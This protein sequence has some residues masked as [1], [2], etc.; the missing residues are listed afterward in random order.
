MTAG[1]RMREATADDLDAVERIERHSF[2][3]PWP[4]SAFV[5]ELRTPFATLVVAE[6]ED[7]GEIVG[8]VDYWVVEDELHLLSIAVDPG[9]R[10]RGLGRA[11]LRLAEEDGV[12]RGAVLAVLE[13][14]VGNAAAR[15][16]YQRA[17]YAQ[18]GVRKRYYSDSGEDALVLLKYID[19]EHSE[20]TACSGD[21]NES[22]D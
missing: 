14:R 7:G 13:V 1:L 20:K 3:A 17:G 16:L 12:E 2:G 11:L 18:V 19:A 4:R 6:R 21:V 9:E 22:K 8:F 10:R 5:Q 15:A